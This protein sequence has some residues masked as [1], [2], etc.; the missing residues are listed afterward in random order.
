[1]QIKEVL[2]FCLALTK[3]S[4]CGF[5]QDRCFRMAAALSYSTLFALVPLVVL[6][7][8]VFNAFPALSQVTHDLQVFVMQNLVAHSAKTLSIE[9]SQFVAQSRELSIIGVLFLI[10]VAVLMVFTMEKAFNEIWRVSHP[11]RGV[12]GFLMYWGVITLMPVLL[13]VS[14]FI[15]SHVWS[16]P[17]VSDTVR[18]LH[19]QSTLLWLGPLAV[20]FSAM[21][22][23]YLS[24]PNCSVSISAAVISSMT[25][26]V[27]FLVLRSIYVVYVHHA[28]IEV[29]LY[30][31]MSVIPI[32]LTWVFCNWLLILFGVEVGYH[33]TLLRQQNNDQNTNY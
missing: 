5:L 12:S 20:I 15:S 21:F 23:I 7:V 32:F 8:L 28:S 29:S 1:V 26:T 16:L 30:G 3:H 18:A 31:A 19:L 14:L 24:L 10:A 2:G 27:C 25:V 11:R 33:F 6:V 17:W 4:I 13:G 22:F 9:F